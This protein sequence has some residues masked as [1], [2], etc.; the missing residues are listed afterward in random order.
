MGIPGPFDKLRAEGPYINWEY[1]DQLPTFDGSEEFYAQGVSI[2]SGRGVARTLVRSL[3]QTS[4][5]LQEIAQTR[6]RI[7]FDLDIL[8]G[9]IGRFN[10]SLFVD[11]RKH[12]SGC[13]KYGYRLDD[14]FVKFQQENIT[15][16]PVGV[17]LLSLLEE[18]CKTVEAFM[19]THYFEQQTES[20]YIA[21]AEGLAIFWWQCGALPVADIVTGGGLNMAGNQDLMGLMKN[22]ESFID[23]TEAIQS[24]N[25]TPSN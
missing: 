20:D 3:V 21:L 14:L 22:Y 17:L 15:S 24:T 9:T 23:R 11:S 4:Q 1:D 5:T 8:A 12:R 10:E 13:V 7:L 19:G 2:D 18:T 6:S 25:D 16:I